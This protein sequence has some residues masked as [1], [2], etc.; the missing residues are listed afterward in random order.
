[1]TVSHVDPET[2]ALLA[3]GEAGVQGPDPHLSSCPV[4]QDELRQLSDVVS[5]ARETD[6]NYGLVDPPADLW[7]RIAAET[8]LEGNPDAQAGAVPLGTV[9]T[10]PSPAGPSSPA[11][12]SSTGDTGP[13]P[14]A[15][16]AL[17]RRPH[18]HWWQQPIAAAV[19]A[20]I[21]GA[22]AALGVQHF[23]ST[24]AAAGP[25]AA[26]V[27]GR[28]ALHPLAQFPQWKSASGI[29]VME[30]TASGRQ[31]KVSLRAPARHGFYEVWLL[32][33]DGV[34]MIALGDLN[35]SH[36]G[37]FTIPPGVDLHLYTRVDISLQPFN[38]NPV[39]SASS[40]VRGT[41]P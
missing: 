25:P 4:C 30:R 22:G 40:V 13:P 17:P 16:T 37:F 23:R 20:L 8:G 26:A 6:G 24:P 32:A 18:Q 34:K 28:I 31:L 14:G 41:L 11:R 27:I 29:A 36:N 33:T 9:Q 5:L 10:D 2:L 15:P 38:G 7:A 3:L 19:A 21:V 39:H 12:P 1:L 35:H